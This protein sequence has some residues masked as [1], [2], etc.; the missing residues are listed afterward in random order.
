MQN[1]GFSKSNCF[2]LVCLCSSQSEAALRQVGLHLLF[3][4]F[5]VPATMNNN[6]FRVQIG[7]TAGR[8]CSMTARQFIELLST[9]KCRMK[10]AFIGQG[11]HQTGQEVMVINK[12]ESRRLVHREE[13]ALLPNGAASRYFMQHSSSSHLGLVK[14]IYSPDNKIP[15]EQH[16][17]L[18]NSHQRGGKRLETIACLCC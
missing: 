17:Q 10:V 6:Y 5:S 2:N 9:V 16:K 7:G 11:M 1:L 12:G 13:R 8:K 4:G 15:P 3:Q 18:F 14:H